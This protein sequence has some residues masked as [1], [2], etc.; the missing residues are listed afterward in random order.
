MLSK[1]PFFLGIFANYG[2]NYAAY[3]VTPKMSKSQH[4]QRFISRYLEV[5]MGS[6]GPGWAWLETWLQDLDL[7]GLGSPLLLGS[8]PTCK[9][10]LGE[11]AEEAAV[12]PRGSSRGRGGERER[13]QLHKCV[14]ASAW[15]VC[16]SIEHARTEEPTAREVVSAHGG[17]GK[18]K[19]QYFWTNTESITLGDWESLR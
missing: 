4:I 18:G 14:Q 15:I 3:P 19:R 10:L 5:V 16:D 2:H 7:S 9:Y 13:A 17:G 11:E 8:P 6:D 1:L 12:A